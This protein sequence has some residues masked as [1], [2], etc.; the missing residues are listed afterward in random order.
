MYNI[1]GKST[2]GIKDSV[3]KCIENRN[4]VNSRDKDHTKIK[5]ITEKRE[6][7]TIYFI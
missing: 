7:Q 3:K 2:I 5:I 1:T 4:T 6:Y